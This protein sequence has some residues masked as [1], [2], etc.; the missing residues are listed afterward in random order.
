MSDATN[1]FDCDVVVV[2]SGVAGAL[3][4]RQL[5]RAGLKV[6]ILEAGGGFERAEASERYE[7]ALERNLSAPFKPWPWAPNPDENSA[8]SYFGPQANP[9][10]R[11]SFIK[12]VGGTTWHW[13]GMALRFVPADFELKRR[14]GVGIDWPL[15]YAELE[16][17]YCKAE[18]AL[19]VSGDSED[20]HGSPRSAPYPNP[21][22]PLTWGDKVLAGKLA[23]LG[24]KVGSL[25]AARNSRDFDG[26]PQCRG[27]N[28]CTPICP[29][30]ASYSAD[31]DVAKA[32]AAGAEL[33]KMAVAYKL[34]VGADGAIA[35]VHVKRPDGSSERIAARRVVLACNSI[36]TPRLLLNSAC[37]AAP[38]GVANRSDQ[39]GRN[40]MDHTIFLTSFALPEPLY[41]GRGPQC[42]GGLLTGRDGPFRRKYAAAK[43][44]IGN[45][46][47]IQRDAGKV[48]ENSANWVNPYAALRS[49]AIHQGHIGAEIEPLPEASNRLTIDAS[50]RDPL[51][52]PYPTVNYRPGDYLAAGRDYWQKQVGDWIG[53]IGGKVSGTWL[54]ASSHHPTGT[55]RMGNRSVNSVTDPFGRCHDHANLFIVG[56]SL[57]PTMGTANPTL[58]IAALSLRL[59]DHILRESSTA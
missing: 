31:H 38:M 11:P 34:E 29:I 32:V 16:P 7:A 9:D 1:A 42:V 21:P 56:G 41:V 33:I 14:Y 37:E 50:R 6:K 45:D 44:F 54:A 58:T 2:G 12:G 43:L 57:F 25:P 22:I 47:N 10:Y 17:W 46:L 8:A 40:L 13:T 20:D 23:P 39:V 35:A 24:V 28:R 27:N 52:I 53:K 26:R 18:E 19:G 5:A 36:E 3:A 51:G 55:C 30:G 59:A 15:S 48:L 4:A 49:S